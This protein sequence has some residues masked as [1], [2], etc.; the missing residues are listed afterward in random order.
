MAAVIG[1]LVTVAACATESTEAQWTSD[2][3]DLL[4][5]IPAL[6]TMLQ[7]E[8][9]QA[10]EICGDVLGMLRTRSLEIQKTPDTDLEAAAFVFIDFA[11]GVFFE[12]PLH[13]SEHAGWEA[14]YAEME[15][16]R[17]AVEALLSS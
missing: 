9:V 15:H 14:G 5:D 7:A 1:L 13:S 12:C 3:E 10:D 6:E 11:E 16:L 8:D 2:W 4:S 17:A